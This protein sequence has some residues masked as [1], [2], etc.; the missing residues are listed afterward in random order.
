MVAR[1]DIPRA[2]LRLDDAELGAAVMLLAAP[3]HPSLADPATQA[4]LAALENA[5][6]VRDG[7]LEGFPARLLGVV[8]APKLRMAVE[9]FVGAAPVLEQ[10]W[11]TEREGVWGAVASDGDIELAPIEPGLIPWAVARAVGLGP[12]QTPE[13]PALQAPAEALGAATLAIGEGDADGARE[14]LTVLEPAAVERLLALLRERRVSWRATST[15]KGHDGAPRLSSVA[16]LDAGSEGLWLSRHEG[17]SPDTIV[18][19]E[20]AAPS[21]V[22]DRV[23]ALMPSP[24]QDR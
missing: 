1:L 22:W 10:A 4:S 3:D 17:E 23:V 12:R 5:G 6:I 19:L 24:E 16:V 14:A 18:H 7:R 21:A 20:P 15:W 2:A 8:A 9:S 11:A 13:G